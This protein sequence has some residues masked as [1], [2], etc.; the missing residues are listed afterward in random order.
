METRPAI[1]K[2]SLLEDRIAQTAERFAHLKDQYRALQ[3]QRSSL[4]REIDRLRSANRE[5]ND[6]I[7]HLKS[8][9]DKILSSFHKEE[10]RKR[11]DRV[12]EKLGELQL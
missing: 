7:N 4:E 11:I 3:E 10:V 2:L 9:H 6:R 8:N 5:L 12:L 1:E